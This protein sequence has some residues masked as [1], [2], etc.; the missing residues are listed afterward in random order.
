MDIAS[1]WDPRVYGKECEKIAKYQDLK[2]EIGIN[3]GELDS[4]GSC[5][6]TR[7]VSKRLDAWFDKLKITIRTVAENSQDSKQ[8]TARILRKVLE[9]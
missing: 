2:R 4:T 7:V 3:N 6:C 8:R 9:S 1:P 5:W